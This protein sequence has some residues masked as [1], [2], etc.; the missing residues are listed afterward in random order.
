MLARAGNGTS[1]PRPWGCFSG[2]L[3]VEVS[4][5]V[6]PT[7]VGVF[8][9]PLMLVRAL[10]S[11]PHAR[12]GVSFRAA[13]AVSVE[14]SSPRPWGCFYIGGIEVLANEVF[15]TPVGVFLT[16]DRKAA[17]LA[18]L[19]H[20]RGGVSNPQGSQGSGARSSPRPWGCFRRCRCCRL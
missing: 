1:S 2:E 9:D 18:C 19:P 4:V 16:Q 12:G 10:A 7:P 3:N 13:Y 17:V 15:P 6:F 11:L 14:Q 20:A 8:P 5:I